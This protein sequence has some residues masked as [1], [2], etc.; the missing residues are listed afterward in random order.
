MD[1]MG[2]LPSSLS[3]LRSALVYRLVPVDF[4]VGDG[5][6]FEGVGFGVGRGFQGGFPAAAGSV[7][8]GGADCV[9]AAPS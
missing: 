8:G 7:G 6:A 1:F 3:D 2:M 9:L 4:F 5:Q